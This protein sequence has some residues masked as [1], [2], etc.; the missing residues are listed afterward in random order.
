L[1]SD[2]TARGAAKDDTT[3]DSA[4]SRSGDE[5][6]VAEEDRATGSVSWR[7][8]YQYALMMGHL[9]G[10]IGLILL[11]VAA[12]VC[13]VGTTVLLGLWTDGSI[14]GWRQG[15]YIGLYGGTTYSDVSQ[16][17]TTGFGVGQAFFTWAA[18]LAMTF[19]G[20]KASYKA[21]DLALEKVT[22]SPIRW[23]DVNP[24]GR[25]LSRLS[26]D[27]EQLDDRLSYQW[28]LLLTWVRS[29]GLRL[30]AQECTLCAWRGRPRD[31]YLSFLRTD[32]H[33]TLVGLRE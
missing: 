15:H 33:T 12:Q 3:S 26:K 24:V 23:F 9:A 13:K 17:T 7:V 1:T 14:D 10:A 19:A 4:L 16:L 27:V 11:L 21:F 6:L 22:R 29:L 30:M 2:V 20:I 32:V 28:N 8:Y 18:T 5:N 25:V 31:L